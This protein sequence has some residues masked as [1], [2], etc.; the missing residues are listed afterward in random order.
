MIMMN[1]CLCVAENM[2]Y[3]ST[4]LSLPLINEVY[5]RYGWDDYMCGHVA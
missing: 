5:R 2:C 1:E 3:K 4:T